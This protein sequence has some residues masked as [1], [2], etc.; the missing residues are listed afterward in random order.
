MREWLNI[1]LILFFEEKLQTD[2]YRKPD[3]F[4]PASQDHKMIS[5]LSMWSVCDLLLYLR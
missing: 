1:F 3:I 2:H 4:Y 5:S